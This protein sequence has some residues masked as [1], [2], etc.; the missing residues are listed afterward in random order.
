MSLYG[1]I[2]LQQTTYKPLLEYEILKNVKDS[3]YLIEIYQ[4]YCKYKKFESVQ[5]MF[6]GEFT[7]PRAEVIIYRD[8]GEIVAW[9]L[10]R[11]LCE[12]VVDNHQFSWN[13]KNPKLKLG[14]KS[15]RTECAIYRD[16]GYTE[17]LIEV[18]MHYKKQL[19]GYRIYGPVE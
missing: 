14:Y 5:P 19:Q 4:Q 13:Y 16:R 7:D 2:D 1:Y 6:P 17:M 3:D 11:K 18:E 15:I 8:Q 9:T 12:T 10:M